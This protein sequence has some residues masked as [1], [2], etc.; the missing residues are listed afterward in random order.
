MLRQAMGEP[1]PQS[2]TMVMLFGRGGHLSTQEYSIVLVKAASG[3][4]QGTAVGRSRILVEGS[5]YSPMKRAEW[6]LDRKAGREL[7]DAITRQCHA[8]RADADKPI[9]QGPPPLGFVSERI[10]VLVP[11]HAPSTFYADEGDDNLAALIRPPR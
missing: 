4:W 6:V 2:P 9:A 5:P 3:A 7:D 11:G 1:M 8:K 10:D